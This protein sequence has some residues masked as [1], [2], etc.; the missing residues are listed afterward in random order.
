MYDNIKLSARQIAGYVCF[1]AGVAVA[2]YEGVGWLHEPYDHL[3]SSNDRAYLQHVAV[4]L[5]ELPSTDYFTTPESIYVPHSSK[6]DLRFALL[7]RGLMKSSNGE[8]AELVGPQYLQ[9][10]GRLRDPQYIQKVKAELEKT[11]E[12]YLD[13]GRV[14][15]D[16]DMKTETGTVTASRDELCN[17]IRALLVSNI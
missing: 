6:A 14:R 8:P 1:Y 10:E 7:E 15:I 4:A 17:R 9:W 2:I 5:G 3:L 16:I 13:G 12:E 11:I